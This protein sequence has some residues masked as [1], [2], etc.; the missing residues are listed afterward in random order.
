MCK[1]LSN[2]LLQCPFIIYGWVINLKGIYESYD[3]K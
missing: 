1:G 3:G 2:T